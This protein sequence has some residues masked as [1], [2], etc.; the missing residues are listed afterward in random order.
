MA[1]VPGMLTSLGGA[2]TESQASGLAS[3]VLPIPGIWEAKVL[4]MANVVSLALLTA[5][6]QNKNE[7]TN[8]MLRKKEHGSFKSTAMNTQ[9][10]TYYTND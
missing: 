6:Q 1:Q 9:L 2:Q 10:G 8:K 3:L 7:Q 4:Q 5:F